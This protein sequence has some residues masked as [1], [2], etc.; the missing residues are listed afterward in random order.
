MTTLGK[1][2]AIPR[3]LTLLVGGSLA[4]ALPI[5]AVCTAVKPAPLTVTTAPGPACVGANPLIEMSAAGAATS[6]LDPPP[7]LASS[8][9]AANAASRPIRIRK[10]G[11]KFAFPL[12]RRAPSSPGARS[13]GIP[14]IGSSSQRAAPRPSVVVR[15]AR[16]P[17]LHRLTT[18]AVRT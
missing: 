2:R 1:T 16:A 11:L 3:A 17:R 9:A 12:R 6:L 8:A 7:Q 4:L 15:P 5:F 18:I 13:A 14:S 10:S